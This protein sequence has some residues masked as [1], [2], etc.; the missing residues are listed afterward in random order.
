MPSDKLQQPPR[1]H[2]LPRSAPRGAATDR[3]LHSHRAVRAAQKPARGHS[4]GPASG[5]TSASASG[6]NNAA[7][8]DGATRERALAVAAASRLFTNQDTVLLRRM[9]ANTKLVLR[10]SSSLESD[11][12]GNLLRGVEVLMMEQ[13]TAGNGDVRVRIGR[14]SSPRGLCVNHMGWV[15]AKKGDSSKLTPIE[16]VVEGEDGIVLCGSMAS[17]I[18]KQR[19]ERQR[20]VMNDLESSLA[21][22]APRVA[23][24]PAS[25]MAAAPAATSAKP[26]TLPGG[27]STLGG[28]EQRE[29]AQPLQDAAQRAFGESQPHSVHRKA[30]GHAEAPQRADTETAS[31]AGSSTSMA[32]SGKKVLSQ[33]KVMAQTR[34]DRGAS[35][36]G[37]SDKGTHDKGASDKV[38]KSPATLRSEASSSNGTRRPNAKEKITLTTATLHTMAAAQ[39]Q[40]AEHEMEEAAAL[41]SLPSKLGELLSQKLADG[42]TKKDFFEQLDKNGDGKVSRMEFRQT[43]RALG[44]MG[45]EHG[46]KDVDSLFFQID[47]D[48]S[49][50]VTFT[51]MTAS[52]IGFKL[53]AMAVAARVK[54]HEVR[55]ATFLQNASFV[56]NSTETIEA[57]EKASTVLEGFRNSPSAEVRLGRS[58]VQRGLRM[59]DIISKFPQDGEIDG[60]SF[61]NVMIDLGVNNTK[62]EL[63]T[64]RRHPKGSCR[65]GV[66][67]CARVATDAHRRQSHHTQPLLGHTLS[68]RPR[69]KCR[70]VVLQIFECLDTDGS[71]TLEYKELQEAL[72]ALNDANMKARDM[73]LKLVNDMERKRRRAEDAQYDVRQ[74]LARETQTDAEQMAETAA[75][76]AEAKASRELELVMQ[77]RAKK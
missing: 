71:G 49:G 36:K 74:L 1:H 64:V 28:T 63:C 54:V 45:D 51:E 42:M 53:Q 14:D 8:R 61:A 26:N 7:G 17:R 40:Q 10:S 13:V 50:E 60:P 30:N 11:R 73:E 32:A 9:V 29:A 65:G 68:R 24:D 27:A 77:S 67:I 6:G 46:A 2:E 15:T 4:T 37:A 19:R 39:E 70:V 41:P 58:V 18:A 56:R 35:D 69:A 75:A 66:G 62:Q 52:L 38:D 43:M 55:A 31:E 57:W 48:K 21:A 72:R 47:L 33:T 76:E 25:P 23:K 20:K 5:S 34:V 22:A 44:L 3:N 59:A 12:L 16:E